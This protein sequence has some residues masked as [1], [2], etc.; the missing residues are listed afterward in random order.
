M[1]SKQRE[2]AYRLLATVESDSELKEEAVDYG[3][4]YSYLY[5][6]LRDQD[7]DE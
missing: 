3:D 1:N 6:H 2:A 4:W 7:D 5:K